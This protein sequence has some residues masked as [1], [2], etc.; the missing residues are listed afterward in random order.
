MDYL[1]NRLQEAIAAADAAGKEPFDFPRFTELYLHD[2]GSCERLDPNAP[3][4]VQ[5]YYRR[6]YYADYPEVMTVAEYAQLLNE[7][8]LES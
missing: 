5:N 6:M 2:T 3:A 4:N 7:M 1:E 8:D